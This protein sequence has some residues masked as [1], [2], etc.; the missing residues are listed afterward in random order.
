MNAPIDL[1]PHLERLRAYYARHGAIPSMALLAELWGYRAKSWAARIVARMIEAGYLETAPGRRLRPGALF[2]A[3][4][5]KGGAPGKGRALHDD[6]HAAP[7]HAEDVGGAAAVSDPADPF[8]PLNPLN[9]P[10][11][12][13]SPDPIDTALTGWRRETPQRDVEADALAV[14][15]AST[16][17][18][19]DR[20]FRREA[21]SHGVNPGEILV[22]DALLRM[23]PP[24]QT[25]PSHLREQFLISFA[26]V[27]KRLDRLERRG[28]VE[29]LE[30]P[31][32]RRGSIIRLTARGLAFMRQKVHVSDYAS[33]IRAIL[34]LDRDQRAALDKALRI[35]Q[36]LLEEEDASGVARR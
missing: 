3:V 15:I 25:S 18:M 34:R 19:I 16:A 1:L 2:F 22:L 13:G 27:G 7:L 10:G 23:G 30:N 5:A 33:H 12:P 36:R 20:G 35:L 9:P 32:D 24:Y 31:L 21:A 6:G 17:A 28:F 4:H 29:R 14:R 11:S 8:D 26:G